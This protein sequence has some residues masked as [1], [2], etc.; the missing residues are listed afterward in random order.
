MTPCIPVRM[1]RAEQNDSL[2]W[3]SADVMPAGE[4]IAWCSEFEQGLHKEGCL[5][6]AYM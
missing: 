2:Q 5:K 6:P 1:D 4:A 3:R